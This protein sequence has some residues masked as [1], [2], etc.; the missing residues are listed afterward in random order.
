[1]IL[2]SAQLLSTAHRELDNND[3]QLLYK[4][5]HKNH[6]CSK[7][8]RE[9][10]QNYLYLYNLFVSLSNEYT[11]RYNKI[12]L[13]F[14]KLSNLLKSPP[15]NINKTKPFTEP[16]QCMPIEF[17]SNNTIESYRNYYKSK[18]NKFKLIYTK[19]DLPSWL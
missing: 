16:P 14:T 13:S 1:M 15:I 19:R 17:K 11:Y 7:W 10:E 8:A 5:T 3:N 6:P 4:S 12:H 9:S 18:S 2:E